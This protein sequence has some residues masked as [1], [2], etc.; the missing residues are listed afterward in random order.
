VK[1]KRD[2]DGRPII[3]FLFKVIGMP[4]GPAELPPDRE[5]LALILFTE[6]PAALIPR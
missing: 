4:S 2:A 5:K 3:A 1:S 6:R